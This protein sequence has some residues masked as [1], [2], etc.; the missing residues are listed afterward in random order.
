MRSIGPF[1]AFLSS[2]Y[3]LLTGRG[4]ASISYL[5]DGPLPFQTKLFTAIE[6]FIRSSF[7]VRSD[8]Y[9]EGSLKRR[10]FLNCLE[11]LLDALAISGSAELL[12]VC[13]SSLCFLFP[14]VYRV[15]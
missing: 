12:Q 14:T 5:V 1:S 8:E 11:R 9:E 13:L 7:P 15:I 2:R 6:T 10:E 4:L 3:P